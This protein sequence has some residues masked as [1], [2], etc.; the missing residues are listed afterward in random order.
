MRNM[1]LKFSNELNPDF[2]NVLRQKVKEY[3]VSNNLS[4]SANANMVL[5]TIFMFTV[6]L[7]PYFLIISGIIT[8]LPIFFI[9]WIIMG[10]GMAGIGLSIMH[11]A[12]HKSYSKNPWVNSLLA[13][14]LNL[15][16]GSVITW[17]YQHN[18]LHHG[19][20]NIDGYDEDIDP[21]IM[22]RF[23]PTKPRYKMHRFQHIYAWILYGFMSLSW[24]IDKDFKQLI[25]FHKEGAVLSSNKSYPRLMADLI[26][27][28]LF[29]YT[30]ILAIPLI[31]LPIPW[32]IILLSF[33]SMQFVCG[34][35]L[36]VI[37]QAAHVVPS[38]NYFIPNRD[39]NIENNWAVH[40]LMTTSD[41]APNSRI[42]S[43]LVGGLNY[44][45]EHHL[46]PNICHVHYRKIA[47]IVRETALR[48]ELPYHVK[49]SFYLAILD[50]G[51]MLKSLGNS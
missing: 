36:A 16:G 14:S 49:S 41:F 22:M 29:Y 15:L 35:I 31:L 10:M 39:G 21:G 2:I 34:L 30:Y 20:T 40:Q 45:V 43:W 26:I 48:Y 12:A 51:K 24:A 47:N 27:S 23:S 3:F 11:D 37:F 42:F 17:K 44:Q 8:S 46:F 28:K 7:A 38:S 19:Y 1:K 6:Y 4:K 32:W 25:R 13:H 50:H 33:L 9:L 18:V 5:K